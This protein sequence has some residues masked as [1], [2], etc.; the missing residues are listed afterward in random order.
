MATP[1]IQMVI[2]TLSFNS[3]AILPFGEGAT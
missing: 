1:S 2:P 3:L